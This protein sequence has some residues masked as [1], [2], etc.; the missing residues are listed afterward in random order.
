MIKSSSI[1]K[2]TI[3]SV[4]FSIKSSTVVLLPSLKSLDKRLA[5][6]QVLQV[7][8][9]LFV[10]LLLLYS[11]SHNISELGSVKEGTR[12]LQ[13]VLWPIIQ[14]LSDEESNKSHQLRV[15]TEV[16]L[17]LNAKFKLHKQTQMSVT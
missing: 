1:S 12:I 14:D 15:L 3:L 7:L 6:N 10:F 5:A 17:V 13:N 4:K 9:S 16:Q 8:V 11:L 2:N